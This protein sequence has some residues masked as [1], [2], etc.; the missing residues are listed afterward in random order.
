M[1][2][3]PPM[4]YSEGTPEHVQLLGMFH[5]AND[6]TFDPG[7]STAAHGLLHGIRMARQEQ[8]REDLIGEATALVERIELQREDAE[9]IVVGFRV[10]GCGSIYFGGEPVYQFN[11]QHA[12]R[13]G[14]V[15]GLLFKAVDGRL[16][17]MDRQRTAEGVQLRSREQTSEETERFL[18]CMCTL[19]TELADAIAGNQI[20]I[21]RQVPR[22]VELLPKVTSLLQ[23][24][25]TR[26]SVADSPHAK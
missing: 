15:D 25:C 1:P 13:R 8:D 17:S 14:Y 12:L 5:W 19:L 10:S 22:D 3:L 26:R 21:L 20:R 24:V 4:V 16:I 23:H 6:A 11:T 18:D 7:M 9:P 2:S